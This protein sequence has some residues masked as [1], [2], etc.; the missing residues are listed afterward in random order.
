MRDH[1]ALWKSADDPVPGEKAE[2]NAVPLLCFSLY[3]NYAPGQG[4]EGD[5]EKSDLWD[6]LIHGIYCGLIFKFPCFVTV[7]AVKFLILEKGIA[8]HIGVRVVFVFL[9]RLSPT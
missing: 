1:G 4:L 9:P 2:L 6:K 7:L 5:L 8:T 3:K